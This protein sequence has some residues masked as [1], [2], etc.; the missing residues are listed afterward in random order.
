MGNNG[1]G[2][3]R[4]IFT[5]IYPT[6]LNTLHDGNDSSCVL[7]IDNG[8]QSILL[9]GDIEKKAELNLLHRIDLKLKSNILVVPHHGSKTS[10]LPAFITSVSP[11][12]ALY[13]IGYR[14][15]YHFPHK[16]VVNGYTN[17]NTIQLNTVENMAQF[18]LS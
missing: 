17:I 4:L 14:N 12:F 8:E 11:Q 9:T 18:D 3:Y 1:H 16:S 15:R 5:F 2:V 6:I 10:G 13:A 7:R